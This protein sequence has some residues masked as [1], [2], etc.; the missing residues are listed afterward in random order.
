VAFC[1]LIGFGR[2]WQKNCTRSC[3]TGLILSH[4]DLLV[5]SAKMKIKLV[6]VSA[7]VFDSDEF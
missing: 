7:E 3:E 2:I 6:L 1:N 4:I 5:L